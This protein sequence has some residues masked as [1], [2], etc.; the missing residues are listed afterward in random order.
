MI[1][2]GM[3]DQEVR[4]ILGEPRVVFGF[5][6]VTYL[7]YRVCPQCGE[8][9]I[10]LVQ[11]GRVVDAI[12]RSDMR[13]VR[14]S[15]ESD[16]TPL[17]TPGSTGSGVP[18]DTT[19]PPR[20]DVSVPPAAADPVPPSAV[21]GSQR[22]IRATRIVG[23]APRIDGALDE[24]VWESAEPV[25]G[26]VQIS[27][28]PGAA[29]SESTEVRILFDERAIYVGARMLDSRPD[30]VVARLGRRDSDFYSDWI[31]VQFDSNLDGRTGYSFSV[32][33]RGV[34]ADEMLYDDTRSDGEWNAVWEAAARLDP[35]GWTAE[36][37]IPFSQLRFT[38][39]ED[40]RAGAW[41]L[42]VLRHIARRDEL[43]SWAPMPRRSG[44]F[45]SLFGV[46]EGLAA[47]Q[48]PQGFELVPYTVAR[49]TRAPGRVEDPFFRPN[50]LFAS[51]GADL[52][53]R[54]NSNFT[55]STT[56]NPDFGQVEA[57]PAEINLSAYETQ[58]TE[59]RPFFLDGRELLLYGDGGT[60]LFY[61]RR[62]GRAPQ[63][64]AEVKD[65]YVDT[66]AATT[67]LGA[68]KLVGRSEGGWRV[69]ALHVLTAEERA[70][71]I[72]SEGQ[73][74]L[75]PVE[76]LTSY[77]LFRFGRDSAGGNRQF[78]GVVTTTNRRLHEGGG[79]EFL[80]S[81]AYVAGADGRVRVG[82]YAVSGA[83]LG[84]HIE[85]STDAIGR[86]QRASSRY[87]Q[88]PDATH[89][90]YDS[91][92]TELRGYAGSL[93]LA[94]VGGGFTWSGTT[95]AVSPGFEV[96]DLGFQRTADAITQSA[97]AGYSQYAPGTTFL[98]WS[99]SLNG[100][101]SWNF[102]RELQRASLGATTTF[103]FLDYSGGDVTLSRSF[104]TL[105]PDALRGG[106]A[107]A[108]PAKTSSWFSYYGDSRKPV[109]VYLYGSG[110]VEDQTGGFGYTAGA[111]LTVRPA[112]NIELSGGP[113]YSRTVNSWQYFGRQT[114]GGQPQYFAARVDNPSAGFTLRLNYTASPDLSVQVHASPFIGAADYSELK[115]VREFRSPYHAKRFRSL[116]AEEVRYD[117]S[118]N[119]FEVDLNGDGSRDVGLWN[120][121]F[122]TKSIRSN[123]VVRWEYLPG[124]TFFLVWSHGRSDYAQ[125]G[126]FD[127]SRE[128]SWMATMG[129][130]SGRP[131]TNILQFKLTYWLGR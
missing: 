65:G 30:S 72:D 31:T 66:P 75:I 7:F 3:T 87:Y 122:Q 28:Q 21:E 123:A 131:S 101:A 114:F 113:Y 61:S 71:T 79:L 55:L 6:E 110:S 117:R 56:V 5:G 57:D 23:R 17:D 47:L 100:L 24:T 36:F 105:S 88:R 48:P 45:V 86:A 40:G 84:S 53:Y 2:V 120:P 91:T 63:G 115:W 116:R 14:E 96:N 18:A 34:K 50:D 94:R 67:I 32:N 69:A 19:T 112:N 90:E 104:A 126:A 118:T 125:D 10:V 58:L 22:S 62:I 85:G 81:A 102:G 25:G 49:V 27:P 29:A 107:L 106:P 46:M 76:P 11:R 124:S 39:G 111:S 41:G 33:P 73:P 109:R 60:D 9:D 97:N 83:L 51:L 130:G 93:T 92:R 121:S 42:N 35:T 38:L 13:L 26:F 82:D 44:R 59:N 77:G 129:A 54:V 128:L 80:R 1:R 108:T 15:P 8:D 52:R 98:N 70:R 99:A 74:G 78:G 16:R 20:L 95:R 103:Q 89:V 68:T 127:L 12:L 43:S 4:E 119:M 37:R 64:S